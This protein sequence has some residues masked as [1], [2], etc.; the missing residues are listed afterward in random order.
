MNYDEGDVRFQAA[1]ILPDDDLEDE[2]IQ[3]LI[4]TTLG[5]LD[6]YLPAM[7]S[8]IYGNELPGDAVKHAD[9]GRFVSDENDG[10][11]QGAHD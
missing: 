7:L 1:Q 2:T 11:P 4:G 10:E 3:R 8:V 6:T 5:M 9:P